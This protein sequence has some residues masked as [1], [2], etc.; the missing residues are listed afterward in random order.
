MKR[1]AFVVIGVLLS[2]LGCQNGA[3]ELDALRK[4][5]ETLKAENTRL[6]AKVVT[7]PA[8]LDALYPPK[9]D[10]PALLMAM[11]GLAIKMTSVPVA[12]GQKDAAAAQKYF[13]EFQGLYGQVSKMV[14]EWSGHYPQEPI[15]ALGKAV[16]AGD[17]AAVGS[18]MEAIDAVCADCHHEYMVPVQQKYRWKDFASLEITDPVTKEKSNYAGQMRAIEATFV[19][20]MVHLDGG[21]PAEAVAATKAL[22][23]RMVEFRDVC[24]ECHDSEREYFVDD[25]TL[26]ILDDL[27]KAIGSGHADPQAVMGLAMKFGEQSCSRCHLVHVPAAFSPVRQP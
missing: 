9:A 21:R 19:G 8:S 24:Q 7:L 15:D 25:D 12:L 18:A 11:N 17:P 20:I 6:A 14:P 27:G 3:S 16:A 5:N 23:S 10:S 1:I 22:K 2:T 26:S 4:E 13:E